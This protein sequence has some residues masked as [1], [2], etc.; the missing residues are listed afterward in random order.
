MKT[1][2]YTSI[3]DELDL[4]EFF[5]SEPIVSNPGEGFWCY[6][7]DDGKGLALRLSFN[8]LEKSIQ[9]I[10]LV[11]GNETEIVSHEGATRIYIV[12]ESNTKKL[13]CNFLSTS[14]NT[15]LEIM[16]EPDFRILWQSISI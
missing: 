5:N 16:F 3:P 12:E 14:T 13:K 4:F 8:I 6:E 1:V 10:L 11:D 2:N 9:T 15:S 7:R